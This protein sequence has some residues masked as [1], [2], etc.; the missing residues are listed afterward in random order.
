[1]KRGGQLFGSETYS[2]ILNLNEELK[3]DIGGSFMMC[4]L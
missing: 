1:M 3:G 4:C 2:L